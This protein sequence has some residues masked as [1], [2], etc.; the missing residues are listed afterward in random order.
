MGVEATAGGLFEFRDK[1]V[2]LGCY[3]L[4][5]LPDG[6]ELG[7]NLEDPNVIFKGDG[8]GEDWMAP[9]IV[10]TLIKQGRSVG[11]VFNPDEPITMA[12]DQ[13]AV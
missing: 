4:L 13:D 7:D 3:L 9:A 12:G 11:I 5:L 8:L 1:K 10:N 2:P 6:I